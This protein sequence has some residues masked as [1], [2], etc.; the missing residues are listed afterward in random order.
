MEILAW[1]IFGA[2]GVGAACTL[3]YVVVALASGKS[4][5]QAGAEIP[6][7]LKRLHLAVFVIALGF[8]LLFFVLN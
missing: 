2:M 4:A 7:W 5:K 3:G 8:V 1:I 6:R